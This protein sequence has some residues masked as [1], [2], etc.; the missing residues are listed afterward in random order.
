MIS[1][2]K[3]AAPAELLDDEMVKDDEAADAAD[4]AAPDALAEGAEIKML[5]FKW[6]IV[7]AEPADD[8]ED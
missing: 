6:E 3:A 4:A 1:A 2:G 8:D 5:A 7:D